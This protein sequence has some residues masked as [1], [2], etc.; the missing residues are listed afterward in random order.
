M[1]RTSASTGTIDARLRRRVTG[2][3]VAAAV[4]GFLFGFDSSVIN[5]AVD[6][7]GE[8]FGL[9]P[10]VQGFAVAIALLGCAV[11]AYLAGGLADRMGRLRVMLIGAVLFLVS[12]LGAG[13]AFGVWDFMFW[14]LIGGFGIGVASVIAPTYIAEV[15]PATVRGRL[16]SLQQLGTPLGIF[17]PS[18]RTPCSPGSAPPTPAGSSCSG[19]PRGA[20][21]SSSA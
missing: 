4:G 3:A 18:S 21:C 12:S 10:S 17:A 6:A 14:R 11:G 13:L 1:T 5:G 16:A 8:A 15:V 7:I 19:C 9:G 20:G 2:L